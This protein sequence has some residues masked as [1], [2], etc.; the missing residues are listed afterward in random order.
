MSDKIHPIL[1]TEFSEKFVDHMRDAMLLSF[2]KYGAIKEGF[3]EK[4]DAVGS[5]MI[6]LEKYAKTGNTEFLIDVAN[7]A[8]IEFM[9]PRHPQAHYKSEDSGAS[10]GR[11]S[12]EN[13]RLGHLNNKEEDLKKG[14]SERSSIANIRNKLDR[15]GFG[16]DDV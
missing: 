7:F 11:I 14:F 16:G 13:G 4:I 10:P 8:M 9:L 2:Y 5:L 12:L 15:D 1:K 6:R 3:P